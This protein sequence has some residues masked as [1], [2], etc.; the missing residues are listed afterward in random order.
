MNKPIKKG[1]EQTKNRNDAMQEGGKRGKTILNLKMTNGTQFQCR[2]ASFFSPYSR[3][4]LNTRQGKA[5]RARHQAEER[6]TAPPQ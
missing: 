3:P 4:P 6:K 5:T 1:K 2:N